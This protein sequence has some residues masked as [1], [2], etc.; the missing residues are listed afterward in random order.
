VDAPLRIVCAHLLALSLMAGCSVSSKAGFCA[1]A[2]PLRP[3]PEVIAVMSDAEVAAMLAHNRKGA[4]LC[5][6]RP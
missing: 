2:K 4:A 5:G 3:S 6:W 1:I